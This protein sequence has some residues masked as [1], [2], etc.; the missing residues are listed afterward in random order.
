MKKITFV[1]A[2]CLILILTACNSEVSYPHYVQDLC[3]LDISGSMVV[4]SG[5]S[6]GGFHG[7][8]ALMVKFDCTQISDSVIQQLD[9]WNTL[10]L[11]ENLQL[12]MYG[13]T[14]DGTVYAHE[15]AERYG[16]PEV[17]NGYYYFVDRHSESTDSAS[18]NNLFSRSSWNFSLVIYDSDN[19]HLY[20]FEFDT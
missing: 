9:S 14:K 12:I 20:L 2:L 3:D 8:G 17:Q 19:A 1:I 16:I 6:H 4:S 15:L 13:G 10:P 7:D 5:D 18:D 11:S